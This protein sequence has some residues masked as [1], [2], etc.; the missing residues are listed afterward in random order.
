MGRH[1]QYRDIESNHQRR[2]QGGSR[3][4]AQGKRAGQRIIQYRLHLR[5][6]KAKASADHHRHQRVGQPDIFNDY[7][8]AGIDTLRVE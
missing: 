2:P 3:T 4:D 1:P 6:G 7:A 5:P 8:G